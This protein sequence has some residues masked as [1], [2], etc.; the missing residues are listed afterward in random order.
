M[1]FQLNILSHEETDVVLLVEKGC[2]FL[3]LKAGSSLL[4]PRIFKIPLDINVLHPF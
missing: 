4:S 1:D 2:S 3:G